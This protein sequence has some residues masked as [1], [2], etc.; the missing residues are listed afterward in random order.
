ML[1]FQFSR[2]SAPAAASIAVRLTFSLL[3]LAFFVRSARLLVHPIDC[4]KSGCQPQE[5]LLA[6]PQVTIEKK[7]LS[8]RPLMAVPKHLCNLAGSKGCRIG[9]MQL[10]HE[11]PSGPNPISQEYPTSF[12][13]IKSRPPHP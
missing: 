1:C 8:Q 11:V 9:S 12:H 6:M 5:L 4:L 3:F 2:I 10:L 13:I 7:K